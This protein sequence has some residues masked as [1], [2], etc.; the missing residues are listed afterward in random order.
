MLR[1]DRHRDTH[2]DRDAGSP[3]VGAHSAHL[4]AGTLRG[5][6]GCE[7]C[8]LVPKQ[9]LDVGHVDSPPPAEVFDSNWLGGLARADGAQ[10]TFDPVAATCG[11]VYCHG[12]GN[13]LVASDMTPSLIRTPKWN[14]GSSQAKCGTC[15]GTPP[16]DGKLEHSNVTSVQACVQCHALSVN[17]DGTI[18]FFS[19]GDGGT[20]SY[21]L[22]GDVNGNN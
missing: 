15:H 11:S 9:V 1:R 22:N 10:P 12:G 3:T 7:E 20:F 18:R 5:P 6:L 16:Q 21:H 14:G 2:G 17:A 19:L 8:H 4:K 13:S